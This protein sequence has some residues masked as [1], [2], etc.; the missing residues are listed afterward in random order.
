ME[1]CFVAAQAGTIALT[2]THVDVLLAGVDLLVRVGDP[3]GQPV[4]QTEIDVFAA[5]LTGADGA[6]DAAAAGA[7][8]GRAVSGARR[9]RER[10]RRGQRRG[11]AACGIGRVPDP[12]QPAAWPAPA[13][14]VACVRIR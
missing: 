1:E 12:A 4:T 5:A 11:A 7:A 8:V 14:C 10:T 2:A 3:Q 13:R 9:R 6:R